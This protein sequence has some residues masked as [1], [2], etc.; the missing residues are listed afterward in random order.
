MNIDKL[1]IVI[2]FIMIKLAFHNS[3]SLIIYNN[4]ENKTI[5][6]IKNGVV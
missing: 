2:T 6:R 1:Q 3:I 5:L 4:I